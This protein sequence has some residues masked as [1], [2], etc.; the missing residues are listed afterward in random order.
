MVD[1]SIAPGSGPQRLPGQR[2]VCRGS[3]ASVLPRLTLNQMDYVEK[4]NFRRN[5]SPEHFAG[6]FRRNISPEH[7]AGTFRR[8]ISPEHFAG[9]FRRNISPEIFTLKKLNI[10]NSAPIRPCDASA[11]DD[12]VIF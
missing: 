11:D 4:E 9:T 5:I 10:L 8:N 3:A 2:S 7:F 12:Y 1:S 6:T